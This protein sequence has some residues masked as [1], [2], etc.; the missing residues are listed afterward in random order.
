[1]KIL[2]DVCSKP[3][4]GEPVRGRIWCSTHLRDWHRKH[5]HRRCHW[6][7]CDTIIAPDSGATNMVDGRTM[8]TGKDK[9]SYCRWHEVEHLRPNPQV[10]EINLRRLGEG[11]EVVGD[12]W[13]PLP[14]FTR[15]NNG[16]AAFDVEGS[17]G[18]V[19]WPYHR[20]VWDMLMGG[21]RQRQELDHLT[22][23]VLGSSCCSPAHLQPVYHTVNMSRRAAR[24]AARKARKPFS[25]K[26][27]GPAVNMDAIA[28]E[29][30]QAFAEQ[31][32]LPLPARGNILFSRNEFR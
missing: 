20:A 22:G 29:L 26:T 25:P 24:N 7:D 11:L 18:K 14:K 21:H 8:G 2:I 19:H 3:G 6:P 12:C 27:C 1:L 32:G 5:G 31:H 4:C 16:A 30:V 15:F 17:N 10:E 9:L 28:S 13:K 23:C